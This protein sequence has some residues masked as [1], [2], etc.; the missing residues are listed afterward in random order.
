METIKST[1]DLSELKPLIDYLRNKP[2]KKAYLFGSYARGEQT[3]DSDMDILLE[4][5]PDLDPEEAGLLKLD[6]YDEVE[7]ILGQRVDI[8][9]EKYLKNKYLIE[10]I[11]E[12]KI[13]FYEKG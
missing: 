11:A 13:L 6:M 4:M 8:I 12:D 5:M 10:S 9:D 3:Q 1:I 2:V 7:E